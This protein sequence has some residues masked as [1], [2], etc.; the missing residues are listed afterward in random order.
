MGGEEILRVHMG[1]VEGSEAVAILDGLRTEGQIEGERHARLREAFAQMHGTLMRTMAHEK[2]LLEEAKALK[3]RVEEENL[4]LQSV[5]GRTGDDDNLLSSLRED[6]EQAETEAALCREREQALML[7]VNELQRERD[8]RRDEVEA[9]ERDYLAMMEPRIAQH[10]DDIENITDEVMQD[11]VKLEASRKEAG[12]LQQ[13]LED[14]L[15]VLGR[16]KEDLVKEKVEV[17][18]A[19]CRRRSGSRGRSR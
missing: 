5:S 10:K 15:G 16:V 3:T 18:K 8:E 6:A 17:E 19:R 14:T 11:K 1:D 9:L 2:E 4:E 13:N 7:E 12:A